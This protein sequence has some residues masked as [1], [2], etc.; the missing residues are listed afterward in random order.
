MAESDRLLGMYLHMARASS[1]RNQPMVQD[2][3][4]V[5]A[6]VQAEE[7]GL[8]E[9][10]ALCRHKILGHNAR[11]L[12]RKWP[13]IGEALSSE[14]FQTY[15]KQLKRRYS[16]EKVEHMMHSLGIEMGQE[17]EAYFSDSEYAAALLDTRVDAIGDV[18]AQDP[19]ARAANGRPARR[20][21]GARG[22]KD[23]GEGV[24]RGLRNLLVVWAP[25][26]A[27]L[28]A[29]VALALASRAMGP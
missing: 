28:L 22:P 25:F 6:G 27:G 18:L 12:L 5:L 7:M 9:I 8:C 11:H 14:S 17:R 16:G 1:M 3:L 20:A 15:L 23:H 29:L 19:T 2:K 24:A 21:A 10:S 26:A 13:T 4:L